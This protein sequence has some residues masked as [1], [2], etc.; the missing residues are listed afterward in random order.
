MCKFSPLSRLSEKSERDLPTSERENSWWVAHGSKLYGRIVCTL[1][2][3][4]LMYWVCCDSCWRMAHLSGRRSMISLRMLQWSMCGLGWCL[5][6]PLLVL[7]KLSQSQYAI[8]VFGASLN[9]SLGNCMGNLFYMF[10]LPSTTEKLCA[11]KLRNA[12]YMN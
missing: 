4:S 3:E 5:E 10:L 6:T 11:V 8:V 1:L 12:E 7:P 9:W 2:S